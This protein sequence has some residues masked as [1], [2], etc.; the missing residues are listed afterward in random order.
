MTRVSSRILA[1][2]LS[3]GAAIFFAASVTAANFS[4]TNGNDSGAGSLRQALADAEAA[5]G[6]DIIT[7]DTT[8]PITL[9]G[10]ALTVVSEVEIIGNASVVTAAGLSRV[11]Q[12]NGSETGC[13]K[14]TGLTITGGVTVSGAAGISINNACV[15]LRDCAVTGNVSGTGGAGINASLANLTVVNS[16]IDHNV[17]QA[18]SG[19]GL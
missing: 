9:A 5:A 18:G 12:I 4:V 10:T 1:I 15:I 3:F 14:L 16:S 7:I 2:S 19:G 13:V 11:F 8:V 17:A 6:P